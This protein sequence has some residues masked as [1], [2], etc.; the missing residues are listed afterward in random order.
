ME[1]IELASK[2]VD[3]ILPRLVVQHAEAIKTNLDGIRLILTK[4]DDPRLRAD[5][6]AAANKLEKFLNGDVQDRIHKIMTEGFAECFSV[7][8]LKGLIKQE[9]INIKV[10]S[11]VSQL[12]KE[13]ENILK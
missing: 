5:L 10:Q 13:I 3:L 11:V 8:E 12:E 7:T 2:F 6:E 1:K 4:T 9:E